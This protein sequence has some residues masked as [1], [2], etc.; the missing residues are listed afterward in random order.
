MET[1]VLIGDSCCNAKV[2]PEGPA[3]GALTGGLNGHGPIKINPPTDWA[4][5]SE[6]SGD[7]EAV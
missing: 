7:A 6:P 4:S 1:F 5:I 3:G 2:K